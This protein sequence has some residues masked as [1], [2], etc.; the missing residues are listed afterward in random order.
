MYGK[1][2][3][4]SSGH[5]VS[6]Q[7]PEHPALCMSSNGHKF[8]CPT[9]CRIVTPIFL[10]I[11]LVGAVPAVP[12]FEVGYPYLSRRRTWPR[13]QQQTPAPWGQNLQGPGRPPSSPPSTGHRPQRLVALPPSDVSLSG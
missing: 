2:G 1:R 7:R 8:C 4:L 9:A 11:R 3:K 12:V 6:V 5:R 13:I 10:Y